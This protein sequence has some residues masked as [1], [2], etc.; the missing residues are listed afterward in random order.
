MQDYNI[1]FNAPKQ[2]I[3]PYDSRSLVKQLLKESVEKFQL[4]TRTISSNCPTS[5]TQADK[6]NQN[7]SINSISYE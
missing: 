2:Y 7:T 4:N 6:E 5:N 3:K 1:R